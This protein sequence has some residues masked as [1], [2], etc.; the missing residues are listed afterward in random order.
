MKALPYFDVNAETTLQM[1]TSKKGLEACLFQKGKVICYA[2]RALTKTAELPE[3][4]MKDTRN[5][6]GN[7]KVPLLPV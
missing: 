4:G 2:S 6:L 1:D 3:F 5:Y 7:G